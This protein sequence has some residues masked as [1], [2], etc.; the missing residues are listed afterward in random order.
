[1]D[2]TFSAVIR[3]AWS[4]LRLVLSM[5]RAGENTTQ[6]G[7]PLEHLG[8]SSYLHLVVLAESKQGARQY[9]VCAQLIQPSISPNIVIPMMLSWLSETSGLESGRRP[10]LT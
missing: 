10:D 2:R 9:G 8:K 3:P 7:F 4:V 1:M 6:C 5:N